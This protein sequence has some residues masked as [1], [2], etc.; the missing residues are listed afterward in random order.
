MHLNGENAIRREQITENRHY[1]QNN[2]DSEK[3]NDPRGSSFP[4][5]GLYTLLDHN[6]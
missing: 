5:L 6:I 1:G 4:F 2:Y 3:K